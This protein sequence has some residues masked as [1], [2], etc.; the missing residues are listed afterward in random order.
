[1][2]ETRSRGRGCPEGRR[3]GP[4][5]DR[6]G[7]TMALASSVAKGTVPEDAGA[8]E[9]EDRDERRVV[10]AEE[11]SVEVPL[12]VAE[13][14]EVGADRADL[15]PSVDR[16]G[17]WHGRSR[18]ARVGSPLC[19]GRR[20]TIDRRCGVDAARG[21]VTEEGPTSLEEGAE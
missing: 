7:Q 1:A 16:D 20:C 15:R 4:F 19:G 13:A 8:E 2:H 5:G 6:R 21:T 10:S 12:L 14:D 17:A 11:A 18:V 9:L 3:L